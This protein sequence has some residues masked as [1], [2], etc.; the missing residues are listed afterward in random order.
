[1]LPEQFTIFTDVT[2]KAGEP[3]QL[4]DVRLKPREKRPTP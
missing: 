4:G 2:L 3:K 1:M